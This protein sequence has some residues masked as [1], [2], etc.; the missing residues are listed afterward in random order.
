M[1]NVNVHSVIRPGSGGFA[2]V[3]SAS[4]LLAVSLAGGPLYVSSAASQALQTSMANTCATDT[5][6]V[7]TLPALPVGLIE[8]TAWLDVQAHSIAHAGEPLIT[9]LAASTFTV[10]GREQVGQALVLLWRTDQLKYLGAAMPSLGDGQIL[11]PGQARSRAKVD[12]ADVLAVGVPSDPRG[13]LGPD[14]RSVARAAD[15]GLDITHT[16]G[17]TEHVPPTQP[18]RLEVVGVFPDIPTRPEPSYWCGWRSLFRPSVTGDLRPLVMVVDGTVLDHFPAGTVYSSWELRPKSNKLTVDQAEELLRGY[19]HIEAAFKDRVGRYGD[20]L[21]APPA[22]QTEPHL[23]VL[24]DQA[25]QVSKVVGRTMAPIRLAGIATGA[26]LLGGAAVLVARERRR[27]LRLRMLHGEG[28]WSISARISRREATPIALGTAMGTAMS[29]LAVMTLGPTPE[30]ERGPVLTAGIDALLGA[31]AAIVLVGA[32]AAVV[33][34]R[35]V[36]RA[37]RRSIRWIPWELLIVALAV[38][39]YE[40]LDRG[41]GVRLIGDRAKGGDFLAQAFPVLALAAP[42]AVLSRPL[43]YIARRSRSWGGRLP[44]PFVSGLRRVGVESGTSVVVAMATALAIGA[45]VVSTAMTV[46]ARQLLAD[47]SAVFLGG[48]ETVAVTEYLELPAGLSGTVVG[49]TDARGESGERVDVIGV[50]PRTFPLAVR[51]RA[52]ASDRSLAAL[53]AKIADP[54]PGD[55]MPAIVIGP[56]DSEV[57]ETSNRRQLLIDQVASARWFPGENAGATLVIVNRSALAATIDVAEQVWLRSPPPDSVTL[58]QRA[59]FNVGGVRQAADV[60]DVISFLAVQWSY[61]ALA[62]FGVVIGGAVVLVQMLVLDARRRVRQANGVLTRAMGLRIRGVVGAVFTEL[63][64][65]FFTGAVLGIGLAVAVL[66]VAVPRLDTLRQ[67][68]P[69]A[70]VIVDLGAMGT[71]VAVGVIALVMLTLIGVRG[72]L[73]A[74][75]MEVM[76]GG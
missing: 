9:R 49:R 3:V 1:R 28:P 35:T 25:K 4:A 32:V 41:G 34:S 72:V 61:S 22:P 38:F 69:P 42:L 59:G 63:S 27:E 67:L 43:A 47:K 74:R 51:W 68:Q 57:L 39:S 5:G 18:A 37:R 13:G 24:I 10:E 50:D 17:T 48:D 45:F 7:L 58:L 8:L 73:R 33:T 20:A 66:H 56:L 6:L 15:G 2:A 16:D 21:L 31:L 14:V 64:I 30:L 62:A 52:D 26:L 11:V 23:G 12:T 53:L 40:R 71:A 55:R 70:R 19:R 29:V 44:V 60:F 75:P 54:D 36:D 65:P 76:R 46:S